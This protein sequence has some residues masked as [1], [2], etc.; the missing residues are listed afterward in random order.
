MANVSTDRG[1]VGE[2]RIEEEFAQRACAP[3][4]DD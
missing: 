4:S 2:R 1:K 3:S